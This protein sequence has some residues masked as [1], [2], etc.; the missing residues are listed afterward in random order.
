MNGATAPRRSMP[1]GAPFVHPVR[2]PDDDLV[3]LLSRRSSRS[4]ARPL[5]GTAVESRGEDRDGL[6]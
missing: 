4:N 1:I 2:P 6:E 3:D 5:H